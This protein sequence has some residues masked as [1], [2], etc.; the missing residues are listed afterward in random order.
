MWTTQARCPHAHRHN[1]RRKYQL[2]G[3]INARDSGALH[4]SSHTA[5]IPRGRTTHS[6]PWGGSFLNLAADALQDDLLGFHLAQPP[7]L[8]EMGLLYY[9]SASSDILSEA[10]RRAARYSSIVNEGISLKYVEAGD[11]GISFDY[12]GVSRHLDR[13]QIE[14]FA[15]ALVRMCRQLTGLRLVPTRA[16]LTHRRGACSELS[17]SSVESVGGVGLR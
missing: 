13:H 15:T 12:V 3:D 4:L 17:G 1:K 10:L 16:R 14:F 9:V 7:D 2:Q 8:R 6:C 5:R 11:V